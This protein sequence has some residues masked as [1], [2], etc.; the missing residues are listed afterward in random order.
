MTSPTEPLQPAGADDPAAVLAHARARKRDEDQAG[1]D[2]M[3]A[4]AAW[5]AMHSLDSLV[6]P[7]DQW[8]E[9][10][11]PLG[12]EGCPE[13]AEFAVLEFG[14]ALGK[15]TPAGRHY[16]AQ[17]VEGHY[18]LVEC[19]KRLVAGV[20]PAWKLGFIADR[21]MTL[22][23]AAAGFVDRHVAAVAHSI[24]AAQLTRLIE[25]AIA[26]FDPDRAEAERQAA[27]ETR[28]LHVDLA[29][30]SVAG[31][32]RVEGDLDLA[33][34]IDFNTAIATDAHQQLLAGSTESLDVRRSIAAGNLA[35]NQL[36]LH[37]EAAEQP[38]T[39]PKRQ[40]VLHVHLE[41]AAV[42]G[43]GGGVARVQETSG[44]V[45]AEQVRTWCGNPDTTVMVQPVLDLAEHIHVNAYQASSRLKLQ[46]FLRD[47]VC[48]FPYCYRPAEACDCE[49]RVPHE[50]DGPTCS[51]NQ[52]PACRSHHRAKTTGGWTYVTVEPGVYL[53]R[54]PLG[55]QFLKDATGTLDV[56]PDEDR[57]KLAKN[58]RRHFGETDPEP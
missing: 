24:G 50:D 5:A 2:V 9:R 28:R 25:E 42:H 10:A 11:L 4:A 20:L 8:H 7:L 23:P 30:V 47:H 38:R 27:A 13:V 22:P 33:D 17:A 36:T 32:V 40:V 1:R 43:A 41:Q 31:T 39:K 57:R 58:F 16:L 48:A 15:S 6:G 54:S 19:W 56:T 26:R 3:V 51:C 29:G 45:T 46:T 35:R 18:R 55:Y 53:W 37:L 52:A 14:A 44:P 21:T 12:G 34:A 49:H